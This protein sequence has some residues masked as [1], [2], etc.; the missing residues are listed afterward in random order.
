VSQVTFPVIILFAFRE[1]E[2]GAALGT[3]YFK[4]WH[5]GF[6]T[7]VIEDH[8]SLALRSAGVAFLST[9]GRGAKALLF[10]NAR[11]KALA[12]RRLIGPEFT[13]AIRCIQ[14]F[15]AKTVAEDLH[16]NPGLWHPRNRSGLKTQYLARHMCCSLMYETRIEPLDKDPDI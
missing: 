1:H 11:R 5:R 13:P 14:I 10:Q 15:Y 7:R 3:R 12:S 6:S 8:H 9:T 16:K 2:R 4:V